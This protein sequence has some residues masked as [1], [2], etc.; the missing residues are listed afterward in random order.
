MSQEVQL[1]LMLA[2]VCA[3][4]LL[5]IISGVL[6]GRGQGSWPPR[7]MVIGGVVLIIGALAHQVGAHA[8][9]NTSL[10]MRIIGPTPFP[11]LWAGPLM[12]FGYGAI[13]LGAQAFLVSMIVLCARMGNMRK[14]LVELEELNEELSGR[15]RD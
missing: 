8:L 4:G 7:V 12:V 10:S 9:M 15:L 3:V 6:A 14:R 13:F 11:P 5:V 1:L 2:I